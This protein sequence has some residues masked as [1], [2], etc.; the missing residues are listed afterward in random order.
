MIFLFKKIL[1]SFVCCS[2]QKSFKN[3]FFCPESN[4]SLVSNSDVEL[5]DEKD[6]SSE[7]EDKLHINKYKKLLEGIEETER[8]K[9]EKQIE[10]TWDIGKI[11]FIFHKQT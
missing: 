6:A 5:N 7:D 3:F 9:E 4:A 8:K 2:N 1:F 11:F 10:V